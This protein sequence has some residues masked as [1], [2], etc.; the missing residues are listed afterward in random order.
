M[1]KIGTNLKEEIRQELFQ[2]VSESRDIF[3]FNVAEMAGIPKEVMCHK[4][5]I[6]PGYKPVKQG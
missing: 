3:A 4:L 6:R 5:N 2:V 1:I